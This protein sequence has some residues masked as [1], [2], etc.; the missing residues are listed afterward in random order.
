MKQIFL[1]YEL[2]DELSGYGGG[3]RIEI[4]TERDMCCGDTSNNT[5]F[6]MPTHY[7][8]HLDFPFHFSSEGKTGSVYSAEDF[9]FDS[10]ELIE[11]DLREREVPLIGPEDLPAPLNPEATAVIIKT[12]FCELR[13]EDRY[14][15]NG[16]G[17]QTESAAALKEKWPDS[18]LIGFDSISL[19]NFQN[20]PLG[21]VAHKAFLIENDLLIL[22]DMDLRQ[23]SES[24]K[25]D[26]LIVAPLRMKNA[27]GAP[28]TV[29]AQLKN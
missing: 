3:D 5:S 23:V 22:E 6:W 17:F 2:S 14:Y 1:S 18:K 13:P 15:S 7:G 21:R 4:K 25:I 19:T 11:L 29:F 27:D 9:V 24:T 20:R 10:V 16:P 12:F 28:V 8:T 26:N